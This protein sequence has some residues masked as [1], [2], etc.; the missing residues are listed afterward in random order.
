MRNQHAA[1]S[2]RLSDP[3]FQGSIVRACLTSVLVLAA[4]PGDLRDA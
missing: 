3:D 4:T 1:V 2:R